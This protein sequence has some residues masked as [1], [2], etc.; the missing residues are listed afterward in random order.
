MN[1]YVFIGIILIPF[2]DRT[3]NVKIFKGNDRF[4]TAKQQLKKRHRYACHDCHSAIFFIPVFPHI[5]LPFGLKTSLTY[6]LSN[7][8]MSNGYSFVYM[9]GDMPLFSTIVSLVKP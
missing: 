3:C 1:A 6:C 5:R 7:Q 2:S 9:Y 8:G 4:A